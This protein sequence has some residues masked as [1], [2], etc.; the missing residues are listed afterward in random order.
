MGGMKRKGE[1]NHTSLDKGAHGAAPWPPPASDRW[2]GGAGVC[3]AM[4]RGGLSGSRP[5]E[6]PPLSGRSIRAQP[7]CALPTPRARKSRLAPSARGEWGQRKESAL[8]NG[9]HAQQSETKF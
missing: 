8:R 1:L 4:R 5:K 7:G 3:V 6:T 9:R 2:G